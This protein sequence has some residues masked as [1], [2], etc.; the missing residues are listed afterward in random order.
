MK[1][2]STGEVGLYNYVHKYL[3]N[4]TFLGGNFASVNF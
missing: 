4:Y 2:C 1:H 3:N